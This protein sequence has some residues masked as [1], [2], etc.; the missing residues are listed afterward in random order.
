MAGIVVAGYM[1][2][3]DLRTYGD[4][5]E[6]DKLVAVDTFCQCKDFERNCHLKPR[7]E[8]WR[9]S[10]R[11]VIDLPSNLTTNSRLSLFVVNLHWLGNRIARL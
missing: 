5:D 2:N 6:P 4:I 11:V 8:Y 1:D 10:S 7:I 9:T 3:S